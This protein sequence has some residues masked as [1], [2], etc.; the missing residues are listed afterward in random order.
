MNKEVKKIVLAGLFLSIGII[1]PP[2]VGGLGPVVS[3]I[4]FPVILCG[5]LL[6]WKY[7]LIVGL[8]TPPLVSAMWG[9]QLPMFPIALIMSF[10]CA[11]Y[12]FLSGFIYKKIQLFKNQLKNLYFAL[13]VSMI[14]GRI[15]Y[16]LVIGFLFLIGVSVQSFTFYIGALFVTSLPGII[17][18]ILVIPPIVLVIEAEDAKGIA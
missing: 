15:V 18:Q 10:E 6:G 11:A 2:L 7:G 13:I 4:H 5:L 14:M 17:L 9:G 1:L 3:P 8:I 16:L 12:G